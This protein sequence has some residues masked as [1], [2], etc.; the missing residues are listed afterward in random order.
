MRNMETSSTS[1]KITVIIPAYNEEENLPE[2]IKSVNTVLSGLK[3][4]YTIIIMDNASTDATPEIVRQ[5]QKENSNIIGIRNPINLGRN[6]SLLTGLKH[7]SSGMVCFIDADNQYSAKDIC[8]L[9]EKIKNGADLVCGYRKQ[10]NDKGY[11]KVLSFFFN[12]INKTFFSIKMK[13]VNCGMKAM[14]HGSF[15]K[16]TPKFSKARWFFDTELLVRAI[17]EGLKIEEVEVQH[18]E[19]KKG[20]SKVNCFFVALETIWYCML[21]KIDISL[22]NLITYIEKR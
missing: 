1:S 20:T 9:I 21:L 6:N 13:D 3:T 5:F 22:K 15:V 7:V 12:T 2:V 4:P 19:R 17:N 16:C 8:V 18:F 10:R 14:T 11:R